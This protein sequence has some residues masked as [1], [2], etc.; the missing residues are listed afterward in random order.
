MEKKIAVLAGDG[1]GPEI[2]AEAVKVLD[3][4]KKKFALEWTYEKAFVG[5]VGIDNKGKALPDETVEICKSADAILFGS[6]GGP[7]WEHLPPEAQP[8]RGALLPLRIPVQAVVSDGWPTPDFLERNE[9][10]AADLA[11]QGR[12]LHGHA[13]RG[14]PRGQR[15]IQDHVHTLDL[16]QAMGGEP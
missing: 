7:K 13:Q 3:A 2:T 4:F 5:G 12:D 11:V 1:I 16:E 15:Q 9:Q 8:E 10:E 6:V 14:L